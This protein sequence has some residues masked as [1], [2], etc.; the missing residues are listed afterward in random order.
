MLF[1]VLRSVPRNSAGQA[2]NK[3]TSVLYSV[4]P[5]KKIKTQNVVVSLRQPDSH[6]VGT[7]RASGSVLQKAEIIPI[8]FD[9][10]GLLLP[11][12]RYNFHC[13]FCFFHITTYLPLSASFLLASLIS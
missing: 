13:P 11:I 4:Q 7:S 2:V 10:I 5:I 1:S 6:R 3:K 12:S 8:Y 9:G